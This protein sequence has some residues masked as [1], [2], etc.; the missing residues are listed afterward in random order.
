[1]LKDVSLLNL[2]AIAIGAVPG[3]LSRYYITEWCK[4]VFGSKF[5]YGT[6][7]INITGCFVMG[8]F[9]TLISG[10][11]GFPIELRLLVATGFLGAYTTFST[12]GFDTLT[13]W[14]RGNLALTS[15]YWAGSAIFGVIAVALG[16]GLAQL[17]PS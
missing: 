16:I 3:A 15:F 7:L 6:F 11:K 1:M 17:I 12:Y 9:V 4:K 8:F 14:R 10:I 2:I 5:P 13:L